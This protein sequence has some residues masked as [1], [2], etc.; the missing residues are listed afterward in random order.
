MWNKPL[1]W[2]NGYPLHMDLLGDIYHAV[3]QRASEFSFKRQW[4]LTPSHFDKGNHAQKMRVQPVAQVLSNTMAATINQVCKDSAIYFPNIPF[5][6]RME[7]LGPVQKL[8]KKMN[9][10]FDLC[11]S[12]NPDWNTKWVVWVMP[13]NAT[14]VVD[15]HLS[16][17][18]W[19][20]EWQDSLTGP[21]GKVQKEHFIPDK[22]FLSMKR[23][24]YG[25]VLIIY[26]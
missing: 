9:D 18:K 5:K 15:E 8:C 24:C 6:Q 11:I 20:H 13:N 25:F 1:Q 16:T 10:W 12:R 4:K 17:L 14:T 23:C 19:L 21:D 2:K 3:C 22:T 7:R 26:Y